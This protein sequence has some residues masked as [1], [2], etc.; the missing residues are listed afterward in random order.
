MDFNLFPNEI[1][2]K[3]ISFLS[4]ED[5]KNVAF[6]SRRMYQ[7]TLTR[8][9]SKVKYRFNKTR[10]LHFLRKIRNFPI[11]EMYSANFSCTLKEIVETVPQLK[12]LHVFHRNSGIGFYTLEDLTSIK[13]P[14]TLR[15]K[16]LHFQQKEDFG[17]LL[18]VAEKCDV[19]ELTVDHIT[20]YWAE[21]CPCKW[22][23]EQLKVVNERFNVNHIYIN[24]LDITKDSL[25]DFIKILSNMK[26]TCV[27]AVIVYEET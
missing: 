3:I 1:L 13:I 19:R 12:L 9:W 10:S 16:V 26:K 2:K 27:D 20:N 25:K 18:E 8:L 7:L 11:K 23:P 15:T 6:T 24:C 21:K 22:S 17:R 4:K 14:I 5:A